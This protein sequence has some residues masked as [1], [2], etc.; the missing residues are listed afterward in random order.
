MRAIFPEIASFLLNTIPYWWCSWE[1]QPTQH[2]PMA[3][4]PF[5]GVKDSFAQGARWAVVAQAPAHHP[6]CGPICMEAAN[7]SGACIP[8]RVGE[9]CHREATDPVSVAPRRGALP[10]ASASRQRVGAPPWE[11]LPAAA[12]SPPGPRRVCVGCAAPASDGW[13]PAC[14]SFRRSAEDRSALPA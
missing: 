7:E 6:S 2:S 8:R 12:C 13:L 4:Q 14:F 11:S 10:R 3:T 1:A 9:L 5:P